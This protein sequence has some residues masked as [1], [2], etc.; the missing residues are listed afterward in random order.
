M[1]AITFLILSVLMFSLSSAQAA[2]GHGAEPAYPQL[3]D[4]SSQYAAFPK[5]T[6]TYQEVKGDAMAII[7]A[8][9]SEDPFNVAATIIFL[10]AICHT[11][12]AIPLGKLAHHYDHIHQE[13][14]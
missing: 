9:A 3:S 4:G 5:P 1:K 13:N 11:F 2:G 8:R 7:K 6:E 14:L 12:V 10:L